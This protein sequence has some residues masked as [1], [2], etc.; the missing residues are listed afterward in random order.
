MR[1]SERTFLNNLLGQSHEPIVKIDP[2][3]AK[4]AL[5]GNTFESFEMERKAKEAQEKARLD[6]L[7]RRE[8]T[9][10]EEAKLNEGLKELLAPIAKGID[11]KRKREEAKAQQFWNELNRAKTRPK[12]MERIDSLLGTAVEKEVFLERRIEHAKEMGDEELAKKF[13]AEKEE[14]AKEI[15]FYRAKYEQLEKEAAEAIL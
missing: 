14:T 13:E 10:E 4:S 15:E 7:R 8:R 5:R 11:E 3:K 2:E 6:R 12:E 9:P 1:E